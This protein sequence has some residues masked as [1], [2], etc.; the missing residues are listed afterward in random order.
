MPVSKKSTK[1]VKDIT[2]IEVKP[3]VKRTR[4][5]KEVVTSPPPP[6]TPHTACEV[7]FWDLTALRKLEPEDVRCVA[8]SVVKKGSEISISADADTE[9]IKLKLLPIHMNGSEVTKVDATFKFDEFIRMMEFLKEAPNL[10]KKYH[11]IQKAVN[12]NV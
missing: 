2:P 1:K 8:I 12:A 6:A 11:K 10:L 7:R 4:K 9:E 3:V 5:K